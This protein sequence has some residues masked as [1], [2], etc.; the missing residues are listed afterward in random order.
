MITVLA[1][2]SLLVFLVYALIAHLPT[3]FHEVDDARAQRQQSRKPKH[4]DELAAR[5]ASK[6][7]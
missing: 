2:A 7:G 6:E 1:W 3:Y 4:V 5:R